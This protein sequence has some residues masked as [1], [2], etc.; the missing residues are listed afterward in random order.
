MI[1]G[2]LMS[3]LWVCDMGTSK[4]VSMDI[5]AAKEEFLNS[6]RDSSGELQN[7]KLATDVINYVS[8][9]LN[10]NSLAGFINLTQ[11]FEILPEAEMGLFEL[12]YFENYVPGED[13]IDKDPYFISGRN[14]LRLMFTRVLYGRDRDIIL[15]EIESR[16]QYIFPQTR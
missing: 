6:F 4:P 8:R 2:G 16:K 13:L 7:E 3:P 15:A 10:K 9:Q 5:E 1:A 11:Y 14:Y 12:I